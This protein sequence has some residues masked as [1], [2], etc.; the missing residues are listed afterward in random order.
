MDRQ[1]REGKAR[2]IDSNSF[3]KYLFY[4]MSLD[5]AYLIETINLPH[6]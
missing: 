2:G 5:N 4:I 6:L 3:F 1:S